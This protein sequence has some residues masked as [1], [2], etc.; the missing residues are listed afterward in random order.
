MKREDLKEFN[1]TDEQVQKIMD[2]HGA[3]LERQ[4]Q[5]ITTLTTERDAAR[6][7]LADANK[8]LEGYDPDWKQKAADA[9]Q[10]AAA[11]VSALKA[12]YAAENA[13]AGLKFSSASAKKAFL[14]ELKG[15]G[16]ALQDDGKG[17]M[18]FLWKNEGLSTFAPQKV[19]LDL[20][21]YDYV[22]V[23]F[24]ARYNQQPHWV[25]MCAVGD[26]NRTPG[27]MGHSTGASGWDRQFSVDMTGVTFESGYA[28]SQ[29][30]T[31]SVPMK[32]YGIKI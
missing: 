5:T 9:E 11:Q 6:T 2:L 30:N 31:A 19:E 32:I 1:L 25:A 28:G 14:A 13:A 22:A 4:K 16:L 15:K 18:T 26:M 24:A 10:K 12:D 21:P 23:D 17:G 3:D 8:K 7:Q 27:Y 20:S 29:D